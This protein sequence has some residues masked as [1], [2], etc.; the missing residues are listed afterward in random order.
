[1]VDLGGDKKAHDLHKCNLDGV[2]ILED[3]EGDCSLFASN[4]GVDLETLLAPVLVEETE[5]LFAQSGR[6]APL[7]LRSFGIMD[8]G[9]GF[10]S[11]S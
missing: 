7:P 3:G 8:L 6:S 4:V 11:K 9:D 2:R 1:M 10:P 5:T